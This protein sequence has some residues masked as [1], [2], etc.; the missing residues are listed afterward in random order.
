MAD[1][2]RA[3]VFVLKAEGGKVD[4]P[5]DPGGRTAFGITQRT[6]DAFRGI[7]NERDVWLIESTET[8][9]IYE[10][11]YWRAG[12]CDA[13]QWP[14]SLAHFDACVNLG[15][16]QAGKLLARASGSFDRLLL[17]RLSFYDMLTITKPA[18]QKFMRGWC[19]RTLALRSAA[20]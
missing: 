13:L 3:L 11:N 20:G 7:G 15:V 8:R 14:T 17:E 10:V 2:D 1:F 6:Y 12:G 9:A 4:D 19:H 16:G 18:L 5:A